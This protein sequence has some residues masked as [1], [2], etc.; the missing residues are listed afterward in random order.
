MYLWLLF[1]PFLGRDNCWED[2]EQEAQEEWCSPV[3][4]GWPGWREWSDKGRC[5]WF[6]IKKER[7][8][9]KYE[10]ISFIELNVICLTSNNWIC[11]KLCITNY[12]SIECRKYCYSNYKNE[13][14]DFC[15]LETSFA[16]L[17]LQQ[18]CNLISNL[19][20]NIV[21]SN[22]FRIFSHNLCY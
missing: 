2:F 19:H 11:V 8:Y 18:Y 20:Q 3:P 9:H 17:W 22:M 6:P 16:H 4:G 7:Y 1:W 12:V 13:K 10:F 14:Q 5:G 21:F 15:F